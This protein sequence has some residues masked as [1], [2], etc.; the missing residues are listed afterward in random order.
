[1]KKTYLMMA[2]VLAVALLASSCAR[3]EETAVDKAVEST[4]EAARDTGDAIKETGRDIKHEV[5]DTAEDVK[6]AVRDPK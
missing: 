3:H 5:K 2:A 1:M 4:K 6:D